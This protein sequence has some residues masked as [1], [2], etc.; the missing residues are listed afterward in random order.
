MA[1]RAVHA[2]TFRRH[3]RA[4]AGAGHLA[5]RQRMSLSRSC[6]PTWSSA[7]ALVVFPLPTCRPSARLQSRAHEIWARF[8]SSIAEGRPAL[9]AL[10]L[11]RDLPVPRRLGEPSRLEAAGKAYYEFR[12]ASWSGNNE[13]LTKTYNRF[14]D[15]DE[16]D[17]DIL[18]LRELHAAMDRAVLDAYGWSDIPTD[19]EFLLDYEIDEEEWGRKKKP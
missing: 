16:R 19:C 8:F 5:S 12:A 18:K 7:S 6:Q 17:P 2:G 14:H 9:H 15:P 4:G 1:V 13:G 10:R 3:R 11:L